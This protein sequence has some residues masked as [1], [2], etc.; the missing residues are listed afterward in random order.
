MKK[1]TFL[2][3]ACIAI[4]ALQA[5]TVTTLWEK[6]AGNLPVWFSTTSSKTRG[7]GASNEYVFVANRD[8]ASGKNIF[9]YSA[10]TG[11]SVA[12]LNT[13][14]ITNTA[15]LILND[16]DVTE[17]G[18]IITASMANT[19]DFNIYM[20]DNV[21]G[22]PTRVL[23]SDN[24][25]S[26]G[27]RTGD[28]F[29]V[30]GDYSKGTAKIFTACAA[31]PSKIYVLEMEDGTWKTERRLVAT[32]SGITAAG[33]A[34]VA[35]KPDGSIY[36][37]AAGQ[38]FY[39]IESDTTIKKKLDKSLL[40]TGFSSCS[41]EIKYLGHSTIDNKDYLVL[42]TYGSGREY[43]Q[44]VSIDPNDLT[45]TLNLSVNTPAL[46]INAN[47]GGTGDVAVRYD[48]N[49]NPIIYVVSTNNGFGAYKVEGL[50]LTPPIWTGT[51][52][53]AADKENINIFPNPAKGIVNISEMAKSVKLF[54]VSGQ[55]LK[56]AFMTN[57]LNIEG[58]KGIYFI[59]IDS[60]NGKTTRRL[61]VK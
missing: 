24:V 10:A 27:G 43:A 53:P 49:N 40:G 17:D 56:E 22:A 48:A 15:S 44:I 16:V 59:Q 14:D 3:V 57:Q 19:T 41:S 45:L 31:G 61:I 47:V 23:H 29:T 37:K 39:K 34:S 35:P 30:T 54:S 5:Q 52:T 26:M 25:A 20:Y 58:L 9:V 8:G 60:E 46:G 12:A 11:D 2:I 18:K 38:S 51:T 32:V 33:Q 55:L 6:K 7:I 28:V 21:T 36:W 50:G 1:I 42:F 4:L 13:A